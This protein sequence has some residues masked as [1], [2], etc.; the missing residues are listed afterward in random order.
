MKKFLVLLF[1]V[2]LITGCSG[3][4]EAGQL[5][6][7]AQGQLQGQLQGQAQGQIG[8]NKGATGNSET[9]VSNNEET[10]VIAPTWAPTPSTGDKEESKIYTLWAGVDENSIARD[11]RVDHHIVTLDLF[12][13]KGL[14]TE[15][16]YQEKMLD[17]L[18]RLEQQNGQ[19]RVLGL[20]WKTEGR[21]VG[22]LFGLVAI[23]DLRGKLRRPSGDDNDG[24]G[25][26]GNVN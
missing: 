17:I 18:A 1:A 7:Q 23:D 4:A 14:I 5:Q 11:R 13:A 10:D 15:E 20:L 22:N 16:Q 9:N 8:I 21:H 25:N 12:L 24:S 19:K 6:G 26:E 2:A 3:E